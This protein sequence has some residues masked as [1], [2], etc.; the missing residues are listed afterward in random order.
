VRGVSRRAAEEDTM[1]WLMLMLGAAMMVGGGIAIVTF[2]TAHGARRAEVASVAR[3]EALVLGVVLV[4]VGFLLLALG[5]TGT[6]CQS[7]GIA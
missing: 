4:T 7:L 2:F 3:I 6:V 1:C 5:V